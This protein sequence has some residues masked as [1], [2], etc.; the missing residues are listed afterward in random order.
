MDAIYQ[1]SDEKRRTPTLP[2]T[3]SHILICLQSDRENDRSRLMHC[4][5]LCLIGNERGNLNTWYL[6]YQTMPIKKINLVIYY[7]RSNWSSGHEIIKST[8]ASKVCPIT[9]ALGAHNLW[10]HKPQIDIWRSAKKEEIPISMHIKALIIIASANVVSHSDTK[11]SPRVPCTN[12]HTQ[13]P[14]QEW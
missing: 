1:T 5:M 2:F 14:S 10:Q 7:I 13:R 8:D 12:M 3:H 4:S 11:L 9:H 6:S